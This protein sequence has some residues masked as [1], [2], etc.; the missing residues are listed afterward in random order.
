MDLR[1]LTD[2]A[3]QISR[4]YAARFGIDRTPD[5]FL[6]KLHEEVGELTQ[7]YLRSSGRARTGDRT[8]DELAADFRGELADVLCHVLLLARHHDV[9]VDAA[10][11]AKWLVWAE[12]RGS[13]DT[14]PEIV[15]NVSP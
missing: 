5:W 1:E 6:L 13:V 10:V 3:E 14:V 4:T 15:P 11:A 7:S 8:D 12:P 2:R 9:D